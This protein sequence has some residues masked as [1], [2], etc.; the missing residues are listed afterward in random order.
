MARALGSTQTAIDPD[1]AIEA[2]AYYMAR[3]RHTWRRDRTPIE[4]NPLAQSS[5]N[6]G[7]GNILKAQTACGGARLW[8]EI[9]PCLDE[10]TG[11][12][13]SHET[14]TYV[15]RINTYWRQMEMQ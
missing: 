8:T 13:N 9:A 1:F 2:G 3:L 11:P 12:K 14:L 10:I 15:T 5:Y 6:A 7:T 4:R